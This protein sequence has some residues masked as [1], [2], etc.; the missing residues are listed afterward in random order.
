MSASAQIFGRDS[1]IARA[2]HGLGTPTWPLRKLEGMLGLTPA[3]ADAP[4]LNLD[5]GQS[6]TYGAFI[7]RTHGTI[8]QSGNIF[9]LEGNQLR[10]VVKKAKKGGKGGGAPAGTATVSYFATF[11]VGL[12]E[13]PIAGVRRIWVGPDLVYDAGSDDL[14]T[15]IASNQ[16]LAN[17]KLYLG[18]DTQLPDPRIQADRGVANTPAYTGLAYLVVRDLALANYGNSIQGAQIKVEVVGSATELGLRKL[19]EVEIQGF[20]SQYVMRPY[21]S[22]D[23]SV[24][25]FYAYDPVAGYTVVGGEYIPNDERLIQISLAGKITRG[26]APTSEPLRPQIVSSGAITVQA[27]TMGDLKVWIPEY[28][29]NFAIGAGRQIIPIGTLTNRDTTSVS[30]SDGDLTANLATEVGRYL[31]GM[32]I[33]PDGLLCLILTAPSSF[34]TTRTADRYF[35]V[36]RAATVIESG[37]VTGDVTDVF[38]AGSTSGNG[39]GSMCWSGSYGWAASG[40]G[41]NALRVAHFSIANGNLVST[42]LANQSAPGIGYVAAALDSGVFYVA[43]KS[44]SS[45]YWSVYTSLPAVS[46]VDV[47]LSTIVSAEASLSN[48][49]GPDDIDATLLTEA[50][51]GYRITS[52]GSIRNALEPLRTLYQFDVYPSGYKIKFRSRGTASV[53]TIPIGDLAADTQLEES[54]EMDSQ[55]PQR[56]TVQYLDRNRD[57]DQN[58]QSDDR[59]GVEAVDTQ[60]TSI[61]VVMSGNQ[62]KQIAQKLLNRAWLERTSFAF[63]LPPIYGYLE[64]SDVITIDADYASYELHLDSVNPDSDGLIS[65]S[66]VPNNASL[67]TSVAVGDEGQQAPVTIPLAGASLLATLDIPLIDE[68]LQNS[69]GFVSAMTGYTNGYPGGAV[70]RSN[71]EGQTWTDLQGFTGKA[72]LGYARNAL[73]AN[74][75]A[76]IDQGSALIVDLISGALES[77]TQDQMLAGANFAAYGADTR[78]EIIRFQNAALQVDGSYQ[79][80]RLVRGDKGTEWATGLHQA[81]DLFVL[82]DDPDNAFIGLPVETIGLSRLYRG[83][84]SGQTIDTASDQELTYR[85]VNL[86]PLSPAYPVG[87]RNNSADLAVSVTRRSRLSSS[88]WITGVSAPVGET[89]VAYEW[90]V[91]SGATV[92]RTISSSTPA[93]RSGH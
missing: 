6:S 48:I 63:Q 20:P 66:G 41:G 79:L 61:Q 2:I 49:I 68:T 71:D 90:D 22:G 59:I 7:T 8:G 21:Q 38:L 64:P 92:K 70:F 24:F 44:G 16:A 4:T 69:P 52:N 46:L 75:G 9:W 23:G 81:G 86:R 47:P 28:F 45:M 32:A 77:V 88:W 25:N 78:W 83:V 5:P 57:Y 40:I 74:S 93:R 29:A 50:V 18:S 35:I 72:T 67:Y 17:F 14:E 42:A 1:F 26:S 19:S 56:V 51:S 43:H 11:A 12:C 34:G 27:G 55:L 62:A 87:S 60:D 13:G 37:S 80:T 82:L 39:N 89:T 58:E 85:G 3:K 53:V 10:A 91:M 31:Q 84:T 76:L 15:I 33:S 73:T 65:C 30:G 36:D 54:R